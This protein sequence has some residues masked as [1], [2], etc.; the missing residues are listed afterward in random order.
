MSPMQTD[1][2]L[3]RLHIRKL[4]ARVAA[5]RAKAAVMRAVGRQTNTE[6]EALRELATS[7]EYLKNHGASITASDTHA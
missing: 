4:E 6:D 1:L 5:Q 3:T 7:L 2:E